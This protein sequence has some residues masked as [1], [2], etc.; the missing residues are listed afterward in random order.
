MGHGVLHDESLN[1]F[2]MGED[3]AKTNR[4]AII[5]HIKRVAREAERFG[6]V[7]HDL[8]DVI[9]RVREFFR[10]RPI[11]VPETGIIRRDEVITIRKPREERLEHARGRGKTVQQKKRWRFLRAGLSVKDGE[12]I[13]LYRAIKS[14]VFHGTFLS[15]GLSLGLS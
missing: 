3:H 9:E 2:R 8:G 6:E 7:A 4:A 12:P 5:L 15:W 11:A 1:P 14:R 10:V 13:D